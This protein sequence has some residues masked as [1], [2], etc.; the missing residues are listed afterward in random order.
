VLLQAELIPTEQRWWMA[1]VLFAA[2]AVLSVYGQ[3][4]VVDDARALHACFFA[5]AAVPAG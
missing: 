2:P 5:G 4:A 3:I 1:I